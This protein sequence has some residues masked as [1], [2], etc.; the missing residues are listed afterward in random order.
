M[1]A[2]KLLMV[3]GSAEPHAHRCKVIAV[4]F[5]T[6]FS[7]KMF[8][9]KGSSVQRELSSVFEPFGFTLKNFGTELVQL[10]FLQ[11]ENCCYTTFRDFV[12]KCNNHDQIHRLG[13]SMDTKTLFKN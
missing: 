5:S 13:L 9:E 7:Q 4:V 12:N 3:G 6:L 10:F 2:F 1:Q 8:F 11:K